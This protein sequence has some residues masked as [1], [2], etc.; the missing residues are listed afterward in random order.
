MPTENNSINMYLGTMTSKTKNGRWL[1]PLKITEGPA[2]VP[3]NVAG[4][5]VQE[6]LWPV[7]NQN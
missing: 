6:A 2:D 5:T 1:R 7:P 3:H 4:F